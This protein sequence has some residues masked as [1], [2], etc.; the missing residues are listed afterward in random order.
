MI[1]KAQLC[2]NH[3]SGG[4]MAVLDRM[5]NIKGMVLQLER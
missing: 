5:C 2:V 3:I 4:A 1:C